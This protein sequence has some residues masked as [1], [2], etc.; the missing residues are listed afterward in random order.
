M[1]KYTASVYIYIHM[2]IYRCIRKLTY[3]VKNYPATLIVEI[4]ICLCVYIYEYIY[5]Y[6]RIFI[7]L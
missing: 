7:W 1:Y 3:S 6:I 4:D 2:P 5:V